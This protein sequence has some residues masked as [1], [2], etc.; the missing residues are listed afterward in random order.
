MDSDILELEELNPRKSTS[1]VLWT[2]RV[3]SS[4][5]AAQVDEDRGPRAHST[6][7]SSLLAV[8]LRFLGGLSL[9]LDSTQA[10]W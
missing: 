2:S 1:I 9:G 3:D 10:S 7:G 6:L 5:L 8:S 4:L